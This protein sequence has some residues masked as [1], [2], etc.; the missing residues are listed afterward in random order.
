M[1]YMRLPP[2]GYGA[3]EAFVA[4]DVVYTGALDRASGDYRVL[5]NAANR[6][7]WL[8]GTTTGSSAEI[9]LALDLNG[10]ITTTPAAGGHAVFNEGGVDADFRVESERQR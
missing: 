3:F 6:Y 9:R 8:T 1:S 7:E 5:K 2:C 4:S 10:A